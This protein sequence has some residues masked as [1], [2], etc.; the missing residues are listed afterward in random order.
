MA[1]YCKGNMKK[2]VSLQII[3]LVQSL[4]LTRED[5]MNFMTETV[6]PE[7]IKKYKAPQH[8]EADSVAFYYI[9]LLE[10]T[11]TR[12]E[13]GVCERHQQGPQ[14]ELRSQLKVYSQKV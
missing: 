2:I 3:D 4:G 9:R 8:T 10:T 7:G 6:I 11:E 12:T 1:C 14:T 5:L 13:S